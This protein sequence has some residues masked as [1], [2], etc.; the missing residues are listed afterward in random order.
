[1]C[2]VLKVFTKFINIIIIITLLMQAVITVLLKYF[3]KFISVSTEKTPTST[4]YFLVNTF[5]NFK[6]EN[7]FF[8]N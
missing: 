7:N 5:N 6:F 2:N 4:E 1:M 8:L 3:S